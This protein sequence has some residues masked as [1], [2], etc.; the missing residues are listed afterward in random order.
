MIG[1]FKRLFKAT[2]DELTYYGPDGNVLKPTPEFL[3]QL[4]YDKGQDYYDGGWGGGALQVMRH[5][6][7]G[8]VNLSGQPSLEWFLVE[9]YGFF[10]RFYQVKGGPLVP[11]DGAGCDRMV[12]HYYGGDPMSVPAA[13]CVP[14]DMAWE[15]VQEFCRSRQASPVI[16]WSEWGALPIPEQA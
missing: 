6:P 9:P 11:Y 13:C 12:E 3:R 1:L 16:L 14:R 15:A 5:T 4:I 7:E 2:T 8:I 10:L